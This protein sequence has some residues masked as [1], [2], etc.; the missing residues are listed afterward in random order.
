[1]KKDIFRGKVK[2]E[3]K[4]YLLYRLIIPSVCCIALGGLLLFGA[5]VTKRANHMEMLM[6]FKWGCAVLGLLFVAMG[7][8]CFFGGVSLVRRYPA[9]ERLRRFLFGSDVFFVGSTSDEYIGGIFAR[10]RIGRRQ[11][12]AHEVMVMDA[13]LKKMTKGVPMP[14][15]YKIYYAIVY[16]AVALDVCAI[17]AMFYLTVANPFPTLFDDFGLFVVLGFLAI[18][19]ISA[20][21]ACVF[22][23]RAQKI[24]FDTALDHEIEWR[25]SLRE[26]LWGLSVRKYAKSGK[27]RKYW[28]R[29]DQ[30]DEIRALL[31]ER[32]AK[33][34]LQV[35]H[36]EGRAAS[37]TIIEDD[38]G[39]ER[40]FFRGIFLR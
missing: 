12:L 36:K 17:A 1:M 27:K 15:R 9:H 21:L 3:Y 40:V 37:F 35:V 6:P 16:A 38:E 8:A 20:A 30:L 24:A 2:E 33:L 22:E 7:F 5:I 31:D 23:G 25:H 29:P 14:R 39:K 34:S 10:T 32:P 28:Y 4:G 26:A 19:G 13:E 18:L 11:T